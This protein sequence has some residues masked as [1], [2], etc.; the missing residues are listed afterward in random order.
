MKYHIV[1]AESAARDYRK[2]DD[3]SRGSVK[4]AIVRYLGKE[5]TRVVKTR[6]RRLKGMKKPQF[7]LRVENI[8]VYYD[9][10]GAEKQVEILGIVDRAR[11]ESW[12]KRRGR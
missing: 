1:L 10:N 7:R 12:L 8:R 11:A 4:E 2:L 6:I 3:S 5:P 9:V